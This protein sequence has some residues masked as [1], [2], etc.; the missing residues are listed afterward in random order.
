MRGLLDR[1]GIVSSDREEEQLLR[2]PVQIEHELARSV[3]DFVAAQSQSTFPAFDEQW[4]ALWQD[5]KSTYDTDEFQKVVDKPL[6]EY[7]TA[8]AR[9]LTDQVTKTWPTENNLFTDGNREALEQHITE[10]LTQARARLAGLELEEFFRWLVLTRLDSEW[11]QYL[12]AIDDLRQGIGLQSY[13]QKSPQL[14]FRRRAFEMFDQL[15]EEVEQ[16][17]VRS[18]FIELPNYHSFVQ[19]QR[20]QL[21]V[22]EEWASADYRMVTT[23]KGRSKRVRDVNLGR[24]DPCWCGSEKKYKHCHMQS[25]ARKERVPTAPTS[26][27]HTSSRKK[28]RR[29]RRR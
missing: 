11:I 1:F 6:V 8:F 13:G 14:E 18:V 23:S 19:R 9:W 12:E 24:N 16:R 28:G 2:G 17:I 27:P 25:D 3:F 22:R 26:S 7:E 5:T 15:R 21:R 4:Q 20:E 10:F 29:K